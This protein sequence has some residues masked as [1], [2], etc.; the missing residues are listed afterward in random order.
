MISTTVVECP[1]GRLSATNTDTGT[2]V[3]VSGGIPASWSECDPLTVA[4]EERIIELASTVDP[5]I[6]NRQAGHAGFTSADGGGPGTVLT[7]DAGQV[8]TDQSGF[9]ATFWSPFGNLGS[10]TA[11]NLY[12]AKIH[13]IAQPGQSGSLAAVEA[14]DSATRHG[15]IPVVADVPF[16]GEVLF[17]AQGGQSGAAFVVDTGT[18]NVVPGSTFV[19]FEE[20]GPAL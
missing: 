15:S 6:V 14:S 11:G 1:E 18:V 7:P 9:N 2:V 5:V 19:T 10:L 16:S 12:R 20:F 8:S 17:E 4:Q 3:D 13:G